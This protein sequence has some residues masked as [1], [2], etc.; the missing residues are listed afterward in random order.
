MI[1]SQ[2]RV[3]HVNKSN[4]FKYNLIGRSLTDIYPFAVD[5]FDVCVILFIK[6]SDVDLVLGFVILVETVVVPTVLWVSKN[7]VGVSFVSSQHVSDVLVCVLFGVS[8]LWK[9]IVTRVHKNLSVIFSVYD[10]FKSK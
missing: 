10:D 5:V 7:A 6:C 8:W 4:I 3:L 2:H 1:L 9:F